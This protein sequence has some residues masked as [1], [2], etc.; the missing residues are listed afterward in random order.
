[1]SNQRRVWEE[2]KKALEERKRIELMIKERQEERQI[3]ELQQMQEAAGGKKQIDRVNWMY[4]GPSDGQTGTTE[5]ME[6]FLLGKRRIDGLLKGTEYKK[7]EKSASVDTFMALQSANTV[8]DTAAKVREDPMLAIKKQEQAAYE[9]ML[10]DPVRRRQLLKAAGALEDQKS[11]G[12]R[13]HREHRKHQDYDAHEHDR[14]RS[15]KRRRRSDSGDRRDHRDRD[16]DRRRRSPAYSTSH[17]RTSSPRRRS[18]ERPRRTSPPESY[19][20]SSGRGRY[21]SRSPR[22]SPSPK[23]YR[24]RRSSSR[25]ANPRSPSWSP[26]RAP[27]NF[28]RS[29]SLSPHDRRRRDSPPSRPYNGPYNGN[30]VHHHRSEDGGMSGNRQD[31][32]QDASIEDAAVVRAKKLAAMQSD[33]SELDQERERRLA[34]IEERDRGV[35]ESEEAARMKSAKY[36]GKGD[37]VMGLHRKAGDLDLAERV[38]RGRG[39][40]RAERDEH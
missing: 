7:L 17:Y 24:H 21:R 16:R 33:A 13:E 15:H 6:G 32:R 36:G 3:Q 23:P 31:A 37:F 40:M 11:K 30:G 1:M 9:A 34:A 29:G 4:N 5:E 14:H 19:R 39:G 35:R 28:S 12:T 38:R 10:N 18:T 25:R 27:D 8:R 20:Y 2:E 26:D 22:R